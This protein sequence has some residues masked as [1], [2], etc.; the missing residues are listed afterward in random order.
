MFSDP[1]ADRSLDAASWIEMLTALAG[2]VWL[3]YEGWRL[4]GARAARRGVAAAR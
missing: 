3:A 2:G 4:V 1:Y